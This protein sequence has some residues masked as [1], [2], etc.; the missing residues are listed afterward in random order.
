MHPSR[1]WTWHTDL[2]SARRPP[3][4]EPGVPPVPCAWGSMNIRSKGRA[5][6]GKHSRRLLLHRLVH[7]GKPPY[8]APAGHTCRFYCPRSLT[9]PRL[10]SPTHSQSVQHASC[11]AHAGHVH[12]RTQPPWSDCTHQPHHPLTACSPFLPLREGANSPG[13]MVETKKPTELSISLGFFWKSKTCS[14]TPQAPG[15]R[16]K[17]GV[18]GRMKTFSSDL[19]PG[20]QEA[21][22]TLSD[23]PPPPDCLP[24]PLPTSD[25]CHSLLRPHPS[26]SVGLSPEPLKALAYSPPSPSYGP[27]GHP[28]GLS[29]RENR[30]GGPIAPLPGQT[31][32][33]SWEKEGRNKQGCGIGVRLYRELG[34][35]PVSAQR[36]LS[37]PAVQG[38][39]IQKVKNK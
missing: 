35:R 21:L 4:T 32:A 7:S 2:H 29:R 3:R 31:Q 19:L 27:S 30:R 14:P 12:T 10:P 36:P 34:R 13:R 1:C 25:S 37:W 20:V 23:G 28:P 18:V 24:F 38:Q 16:E 6:Q 5:S 33:P 11:N 39:M 17:A 9:L 26:L 22:R 8:L 15:W